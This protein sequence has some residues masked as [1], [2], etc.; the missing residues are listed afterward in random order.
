MNQTSYTPEDR[1][2]K[3]KVV[4]LILKLEIQGL[5]RKRKSD[6][7]TVVDCNVIVE[8]IGMRSPKGDRPKM[9]GAATSTCHC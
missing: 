3:V 9:T 4:C 6:I 8:R 5:A 7:C 2:W 1:R